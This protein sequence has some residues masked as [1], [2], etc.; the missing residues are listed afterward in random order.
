MR[1]CGD[2]CGEGYS[3]GAA[4]SLMRGLYLP[5]MMTVGG[6]FGRYLGPDE[7]LRKNARN[8]AFD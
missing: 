3:D 8:C 5:L 2:E 1:D 6:S 4:G 7:V